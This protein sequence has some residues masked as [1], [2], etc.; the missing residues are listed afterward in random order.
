MLP[1]GRPAL[2][3]II[4]YAAQRSPYY[5]ELLAGRERFEDVPPLTKPL[6]RA[7]FDRILVPGLPPE[8]LERKWTSGSTGEPTQF[9]ADT[10]AA[11][12]EVRARAWLL[13]LHGIPRDATIVYIV[14]DPHGE[15]PANWHL[16]RMRDTTRA[17]LPARL[18]QLD[19]FAS[20]AIYARASALEW[21]AA[22]IERSPELRPRTLPLAVVTSADTLTSTGRRRLARVFG[23]PVHSWYG[24]T[25][26]D[27]SLAG[28]LPDD[29]ER[30]VVNHVRSYIEV[31]DD[32]GRSC[33]PGERG[34]VLVTDLHNRC[35]PLLRYSLGDLAVRSDRTLDGRTMLERIEGR[36]AA[37]VELAN[38]TRLTEW[39]VSLAVLRAERAIDRIEGFQCVQTA[40]SAFDMR[41][42]WGA[43]PPQDA[44]AALEASCHDLWGDGLAVT[45]CDVEQLDVLPSGKRW[46][47][48]PLGP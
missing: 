12:E 32:E 6:V 34:Q 29:P 14:L 11:Y 1:T 27:P 44:V 15:L 47:L 20:Y 4:R 8:R 19:R 17:N 40:P 48:K 35:F 42:V 16:I 7:N 39:S 10:S 26:T 38:G 41:V 23:C 2:D 21:I 45:I 33:A 18:A 3:A 5:R 28:T 9:V 43:P 31:T 30:Y 24:S 46:V 25:E 36:S 13:G 37:L 22:Q